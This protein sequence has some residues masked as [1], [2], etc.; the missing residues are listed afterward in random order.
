VKKILCL[1][2]AFTATFSVQAESTADQ[3]LAAVD[4]QIAL[5]RQVANAQITAI[6]AENVSFTAEEAEAFWPLYREYRAE[7]QKI[8]DGSLMLIKD[9][10]KNYSDMSDEKATELTDEALKLEQQRVK[11]QMSYAKKFRKV[12]KPAK[13]FRVFQ[14]ENR[15]NAVNKLKL[16]SEIPLMK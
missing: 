8:G 10:A 6:V 15:V 16:A 12:I 5:V 14:V 9:F 7:F 13:V 3:N 2:V 4:A 1:L 11:L